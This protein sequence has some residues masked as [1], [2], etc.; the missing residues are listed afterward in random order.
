M[1]RRHEP[2][3]GSN[4]TLN[5]IGRY[6]LLAEAPEFKTAKRN[7]L[8]IDLNSALQIDLG[9]HRHKGSEKRLRSKS[10]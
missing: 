5:P 8:A 6:D 2:V 4:P 1:G 3:P 7:D 10:K 9:R